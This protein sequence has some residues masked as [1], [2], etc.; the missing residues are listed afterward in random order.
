MD[1]TGYRSEFSCSIQFCL[2]TTSVIWNGPMG[3]L[4][5]NKLNLEESSVDNCKNIGRAQW[6]G[7]PT[8]IGSGDSLATAKVG[9]ADIMSHIST[10]GGASL[11]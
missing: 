8:I 4:C 11:V 1:G 3:V 6:Q 9:V 2:E 5:E 10:G 7:C